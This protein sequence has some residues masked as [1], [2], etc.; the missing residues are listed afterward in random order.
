MARKAIP[1]AIRERVL[2]EFNHR[3]SICGKERPQV[4]HIDENHANN[5]PLNLLPLCPNCHLID[6][7]NP[8]AKVDAEKIRLFRK[9]KDPLI[10]SSQ[11]EPLFRRLKFLL[12]LHES[13]FEWHAAKKQADELVKFVTQLGM[14]GFYGLHI[15]SMILPPKVVGVILSGEEGRRQNEEERK[16]YLD[17]LLRI[18]EKVF[19]QAIE[20]LV[21]QDW[22][23]KERFC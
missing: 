3:C 1:S 8:T 11:F 23:V 17:Q 22:K 10:L 19:E 13:H 6:Q 20:L 14:G 9:F 16:G 21:Y 12:N 15:A 5:D 4:H 18:Q 7:H 2:G